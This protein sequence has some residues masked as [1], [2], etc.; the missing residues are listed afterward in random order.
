MGIPITGQ[1]GVALA[2]VY[3]TIREI[4]IPLLKRFVFAPPPK[5]GNGSLK[6]ALQ[7][8]TGAVTSLQDKWAAFQLVWSVK[9]DKIE[10]LERT[11]ERHEDRLRAGGH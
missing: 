3:A 4:A 1:D 7:G 6:D 10:E 2:L 9:C 8:V 11:T 5:A